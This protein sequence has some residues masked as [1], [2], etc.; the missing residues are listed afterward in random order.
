MSIYGYKKQ[1]KGLEFNPA[2][3]GIAID[4]G[5]QQFNGD[6]QPLNDSDNINT[7]AKAEASMVRMY[8]IEHMKMAKV[9][10]KSKVS[11]C[12]VSK[13]LKYFRDHG[14]VPSQG[15][16]SFQIE[17]WP[18]R[19]LVLEFIDQ[20][21]G[22][23]MEIGSTWSDVYG[24]MIKEFPTICKRSES[25][26]TNWLKKEYNMKVMHYRQVPAR[27]TTPGFLQRVY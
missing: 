2:S 22:E 5:L 24:K 3:F 1:E 16:Q 20:L 10:Q 12:T 15:V 11:I 23:E 9:A 27:V 26:V 14:S 6:I 19:E 8:Y 13:V 25:N 4:E 18:K 17:K 21:W 7:K